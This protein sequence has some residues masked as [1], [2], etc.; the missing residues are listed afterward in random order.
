M[1]LQSH[2]SWTYLTPKKWWMKLLRFTAKC[3][4]YS[5]KEQYLQ[6]GVRSFDLR[7]RFSPA[8]GIVV[9]H[10]LFEYNKDYFELLDDLQWIN[11]RGEC[12]IRVMHEARRKK[13]YS[14]FSVNC[15]KEFCAKLE[16]NYK[17]I[18]FYGGGSFYN[19]ERDY[20]FNYCPTEDGKYASN[21]KPKLID[22]WFPWLYAKLNNKDILK[23]GT[24]KDILSID[25]VNIR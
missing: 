6:Y 23:Q 22:D 5:I 24:D 15:F 1:V 9:A 8:D 4:K 17:N 12:S 18:D 16:K 2:N 3:Q 13:D 19:Y 7:I 11:D 10:G 14:E 20:T 21:C 25:F